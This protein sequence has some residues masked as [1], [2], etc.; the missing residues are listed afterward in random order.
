MERL[1]IETE[2]TSE[3]KKKSAVKDCTILIGICAACSALLSALKKKKDDAKIEAKYD[4][5]ITQLKSTRN[6]YIDRKKQIE[7]DQIDF[8]L[9]LNDEV[10]RMKN[11]I[12]DNVDPEDRDK[13]VKIVNKNF[14]KSKTNRKTSV[15][16]RMKNNFNKAMIQAK[17]REEQD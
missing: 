1:I 17:M 11:D 3:A 7:Q 12:L 14:D 16:K 4:E 10:R 9:D 6:S 2:E 8:D 15:N 13:F 5:L